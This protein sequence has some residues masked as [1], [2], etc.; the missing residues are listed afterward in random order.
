MIRAALATLLVLALGACSGLP[1]G[2]VTKPEH[3]PDRG[4][5][6]A[7]WA[8]FLWAWHTGDVET[9][10]LTTAWRMRDRLEAE[11]AR[12]PP[13]AVSEWYRA[14]AQQLTVLDAEWRTLGDEHAYLHA[15]LSSETTERLELDFAFVRRF[16]GWVITEERPIR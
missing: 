10:L 3:Y 2:P 14:D 11:L 6:D 5:A 12:N 7:T 8:T 9:L 13:D 15:V 16:D 4:A 1:R